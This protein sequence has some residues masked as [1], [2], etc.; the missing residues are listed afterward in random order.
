MSDW[1][2]I[3]EPEALQRGYELFLS[4]AAVLYDVI[5]DGEGFRKFEAEVEDGD[6]ICS[7]FV[8][9]D[10]DEK[11]ISEIACDCPA[12]MKGE[13]CCHKAAVLF[14]YC[15]EYDDLFDDE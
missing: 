13:D 15:D 7:V 6:D 12:A 2:D 5:D 11:Y 14:Q 4:D 3:F 9:L 10:L 8:E 1:R